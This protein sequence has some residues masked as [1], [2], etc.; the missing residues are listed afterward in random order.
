MDGTA[1]KSLWGLPPEVLERVYILLPIPDRLRLRRVSRTGGDHEVLRRQL[2]Q[3]SAVITY[4]KRT[5]ARHS[6]NTTS[7]CRPL[8]IWTSS[9]G[10]AV[11]RP[12]A[13]MTLDR[14]RQ[15]RTRQ[16][17]KKGNRGRAASWL[18]G[19]NLTRLSHCRRSMIFSEIGKGGGRRWTLRPGGP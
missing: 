17:R 9:T 10:Q 5:K 6:Y 4:G 2:K 11:P 13:D 3:P 8:P 14:S 19:G 18:A 12:M 1:S 16:W 15:M 7:Y